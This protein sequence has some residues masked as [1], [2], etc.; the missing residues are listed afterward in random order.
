MK[1]QALNICRHM[2]PHFKDSIQRHPDKC[3][4]LSKSQKM[5]LMLISLIQANK[6][7][8]RHPDKC[9]ALSK[10]QKMQ[11]MLISLIQANKSRHTLSSPCARIVALYADT[12]SSDTSRYMTWP[13]LCMLAQCVLSLRRMHTHADTRK[14]PQYMKTYDDTNTALN[15]R[16]PIQIHAQ[17]FIRAKLCSCMPSSRNAKIHRIHAQ[18]LIRANTCEIMTESS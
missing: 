7:I 10:S 15:A 17:L 2:Q 8:Q 16:Q 13:A 3:P 11:L 14:S 1:I 6:S 4:A 18:L 9:P 12:Y 5:Q